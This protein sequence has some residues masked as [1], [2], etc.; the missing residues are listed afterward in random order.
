MN[1]D[2]EQTKWLKITDAVLRVSSIQAIYKSQNC[3]TLMVIEIEKERFLFN[4]ENEKKMYEFFI[5]YKN[6]LTNDNTMLDIT[7]RHYKRDYGA[8]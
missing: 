1:M 6:F 7:E 2:I 3:I 5:D 8:I 4:F